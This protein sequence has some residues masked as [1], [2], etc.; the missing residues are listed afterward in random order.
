MNPVAPC[1]EC[2]RE[3]QGTE[4]EYVK[5]V[6]VFKC[7]PCDYEFQVDA[8]ALAGSDDDEAA[9]LKACGKGEK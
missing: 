6:I 2:G 3:C 9:W 5:G 8:K 4:H 7:W 1:P